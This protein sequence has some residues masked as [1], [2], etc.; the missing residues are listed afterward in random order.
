[1]PVFPTQ[2]STL[3]APALAGHIQSRYGLPALRC[4]YLLRGVSD[5]YLA[6]N[7][8]GKYIFRVYRNPHRSLTQIKG[9]VELL[10]IL[11]ERGAAVSYPI[12]DRH[13]NTVQVF[14][15]AEG[16]RYGVLFSFA[17]GSSVYD[18]NDRQLRTVG[19][20]VAFIHNI[21]SQVELQHPRKAYD[22]QSTLVWPLETLK[23]AF[24]E[25]H[26]P[27]GHAWLAETAEKVIRRME[28]FNTQAFSY[29]YCHYDLLAKNFHFDENENVTFFDFDFAGKGYL[30]NDL[31]TFLVHFFLLVRDFGWTS[32]RARE[33]FGIF[34]EGYREVRPVSDEELAAIPCLGFTFWTFFLNFQY[35]NFDDWSNFFFG[36]R[37]L[38]SRVALIKHWT[39][40]YCD[41]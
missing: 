7:P 37:F 34:V 38:K 4:R 5:T 3:S 27:E 8:G 9:E 6:E 14:N 25:Y 15:A 31:M 28:A 23:P 17:P 22:L 2:Y 39:D 18:M 32:E 26:Y 41:L 30:A 19:N 36:A 12:P 24:K 29:G 16:E 10:T 11:K 1:M 33:R 20:G 13:G 21:T 35:E 40:L